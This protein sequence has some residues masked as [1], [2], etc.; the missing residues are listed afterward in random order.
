MEGEGWKF[1]RDEG[2]VPFIGI[3]RK[4]ALFT[5]DFPESR[6]LYHKLLSNRK[7]NPDVPFLPDCAFYLAFDFPLSSQPFSGLLLSGLTVNSA[8]SV[9][10]GFSRC[11]LLLIDDNDGERVDTTSFLSPPI[12]SS[13]T[14][15][16]ALPSPTFPCFAS[17]QGRI[18]PFV[19][20]RP[21]F[22]L[23]V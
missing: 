20:D 11:M 19:V 6:N 3:L 21:S 7:S 13:L 1:F 18:R 16:F 2:F 10:F 9:L 15:Y 22:F 8:N 23:S 12:R 5:W 4:N 14:F 17:K